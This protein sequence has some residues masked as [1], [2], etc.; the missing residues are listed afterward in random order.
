MKEIQKPNDILIAT[1]SSP[2]A[3]AM[4]LLRNDINI[5]NTSLLSKEEYKN[6]PFIKKQFTQDGV[7]N[8]DAFNK[9]YDA[10]ASKYWELEDDNLYKNLEQYIEYSDTSRYRPL[11][12]KKRDVGYTPEAVKNNPLQQQIGIEGFNIK[13]KPKLTPEEAAQ[14]G[15]IWDP[16]NKKWIEGSAEDR[17]LGSKVFG[18][19]LVYA[20]YEQDGWQANPITGEMG[21]HK[22]GEFITDENGQYFTELLGSRELMDKQVVS[23]ADILT[24]EKSAL[25]KIDFFDSD[26]YE[27]SL[28]GVAMKT[29]ASVLPYMIPG[30]NTYYGMFRM[31]TGLAS[32]LPTVYKSLEG[33]VMGEN[34]TGL[35]DAA[36]SLENWFR[37]FDPSMSRKGKS[38]FFSVESLGNMLADTFG[39]LYQQRGA[40]KLAEYIKKVPTLNAAKSNGAEIAKAWEQRSKLAKQLSLGY[41]SLISAADVY[42]DAL[43]GGYDKRTAGLSALMSAGALYGVMNLNATNS[44]GTWFLDKT[45]GYNPEVTKAPIIKQAKSLYK[46]MEDAVQTALTTKGSKQPIANVLSKFKA[47]T[48][49]FFDDVFRTGGEGIFANMVTEGIEEVSEEVVQDAVKGMIDTLSWLGYTGKEG[50]FG[51]W[52]NVFSKEGAAR[53]FQTFAGGALG[54]GLFHLQEHTIEPNLI[55]AFKDPNYRSQFE[56]EADKDIIDVILSGRTKE[57]IEELEKC[58]TIF[59][60]KRAATGLVDQNG[61]MVSLLANGQTTQADAVATAAIERVQM[62]D[63][64]INQY[65]RGVGFDLYRFDEETRKAL[66]HSFKEDFEGMAIEEYV[67]DKFKNSLTELYS[68]HQSIKAQEQ[69]QESTKK[70]SSKKTTTSAEESVQKADKA[71]I[72][73]N[74]KVLDDK[75]VNIKAFNEK[76]AKV[77]GFFSGEEWVQTTQELHELETILKGAHHLD[78]IKH[79]SFDYFYETNIKSPTFTTEFKDLELES[80]NP[81]KMTQKKAKDLY[82]KYQNEW[83]PE[84]FQELIPMLVK[85]KNNMHKIIDP[86]AKKFIEHQR[87]AEIIKSIKSGD[88]AFEMYK[89]WVD[90]LGDEDLFNDETLAQLSTYSTEE[91]DALREKAKVFKLNQYLTELNQFIRPENIADFIRLHPKA[92][93]LSDRRKIDYASKL[94]ETGAITIEG[95][96]DKQIEVLKEL[97]NIQAAVTRINFFNKEILETL[98]RSVNRIISQEG[99]YYDRLVQLGEEDNQSG[100]TSN[101]GLIQVGD[102]SKIAEV[103]FFKL[104]SMMDYLKDDEFIEEEQYKDIVTL[105]G[106]RLSVILNQLQDVS[107]KTPWANQPFTALQNSIDQAKWEDVRRKVATRLST[108]C[109]DGLTAESLEALKHVVP[110]IVLQTDEITT[111]KR[112]IAYQVL[113]AA[114]IIASIDSY[115]DELQSFQTKYDNSKIVTNPLVSAVHKILEL[116]GKTGTAKNM[117][118]WAVN[119]ALEIIDKKANVDLIEFSSAEKQAIKDA[120]G[121]LEYLEYLVTDSKAY[122]LDEDEYGSNQFVVNYLQT[123]GKSQDIIDKFLLLDADD[124]NYFKMV[125]QEVSQKLKDLA[126]IQTELSSDKTVEYN[127]NFEISV[128]KQARLFQSKALLDLK[129]LG[130]DGDDKE[131]VSIIS[132]QDK[133]FDIDSATLNERIGFVLRCKQNIAIILKKK[134][135]KLGTREALLEAI[136]N[137]IVPISDWGSPKGFEM[138]KDLFRSG[139]RSNQ[140]IDIAANGDI[141]L[142]KQWLIWELVSLAVVDQQQMTEVIT[143]ALDA[144]PEVYP[145]IDQIEAMERLMAWGADPKAFSYIQKKLA[146]AYSKSRFKAED[147]ENYAWSKL[148]L[149]NV[150]FLLGSGGAGKNLIVELMSDFLQKQFKHSYVTALSDVK[151]ADLKAQFKNYEAETLHKYFPGLDKASETYKNAEYDFISDLMQYKDLDDASKEAFL[152]DKD[153]DADTDKTTGI[154]TI[155]KTVQIKNASDDDINWITLTTQYNPDPKDKNINHINIIFEEGFNVETTINEN[156]LLIIDECTLLDNLTQQLIAREAKKKNIA[157]LQIGDPYQQSDVLRYKA[158]DSN[159]NMVETQVSSGLAGYMGFYLPQLEGSWRANCNLVRYNSSGYRSFITQSPDK[160]GSDVDFALNGWDTKRKNEYNNLIKAGKFKF[161][162]SKNSLDPKH[163]FMGTYI[164]PNESETKTVIDLIQ[165][166]EEGRTIAVIISND[167]DVDQVKGELKNLGLTDPNIKFVKIKDVQGAEYDYT[168]AY[169]LKASPTPPNSV[170]LDNITTVYTEITRGKWG[171]LV[172]PVSQ[173]MNDLFYS[174]GLDTSMQQDFDQQAAPTLASEAIESPHRDYYKQALATLPKRDTK[175]NI[176]SKPSKPETP[177]PESSELDPEIRH[178]S[179]QLPTEVLDEEGG[180]DDPGQPDNGNSKQTQHDLTSQRY[181]QAGFT[182]FTIGQG[183]YYHGGV[184]RDT[185]ASFRKTPNTL[186]SASISDIIKMPELEAFVNLMR[187]KDSDFRKL[188]DLSNNRLFKQAIEELGWASWHSRNPKNMVEQFVIFVRKLKMLTS[189]Q[190]ADFFYAISDYDDNVDFTIDKLND[191]EELRKKKKLLIR[192]V[193]PIYTDTNNIEQ[194]F[195]GITITA[196][197]WSKYKDADGKTQTTSQLIQELLADN[198]SDVEKEGTKYYCF[199]T[200]AKNI[201]NSA[202][203]HGDWRKVTPQKGYNSVDTS[204]S[205]AIRVTTTARNHRLKRDL[206]KANQQVL[207]NIGVN[208]DG[209]RQLK[210]NRVIVEDYLKLGYEIVNDIKYQWTPSK[211]TTSE[212]EEEFVKWYTQFRADALSEEGAERLKAFSK[213]RWIVLREKGSGLLIPVKISKICKLDTSL[214]DSHSYSK[215][216]AEGVSRLNTALHRKIAAGLA[217]LVDKN[218]ELTDAWQQYRNAKNERKALEQAQGNVFSVLNDIQNALKTN[219]PK[220]LSKAEL[221]AIE[222]FLTSFKNI[223]TFNTES[224]IAGDGKIPDLIWTKHW[225]NVF[226][227]GDGN[228]ATLASSLDRLLPDFFYETDISTDVAS[229]L[230]KFVMEIIY[231]SSNTLVDNTRLVRFGSEKIE[232][233]ME[234]GKVEPQDET[235]GIQDPDGEYSIN[236]VE[237]LRTAIADHITNTSGDPRNATPGKVKL[238]TAKAIEAYKNCVIQPGFGAA[239]LAEILATNFGPMSINRAGL[240]IHEFLLANIDNINPAVLQQVGIPAEMIE[241]LTKEKNSCKIN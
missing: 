146:D 139:E 141:T 57:L 92:W 89:K 66:R 140:A 61:N 73:A 71:N 235:G 184:D 172:I 200:K 225:N 232:G 193:V 94:I 98:L 90:E 67:R 33:L 173:D 37:K 114:D 239:K 69:D 241:M 159:G 62:L 76:L 95:Y 205:S 13:S 179:S 4:D 204:Q 192:H 44:L 233:T 109:S 188:M 7:F 84:D 238:A 30:F 27:K 20:Q 154:I 156:S 93:S 118:E 183:Y 70:D 25:N 36:S 11:N 5:D 219:P 226:A 116:Q 112:Q 15:R 65:I 16:D 240:P 197:G 113:N 202:D 32:T 78:P 123:W 47:Q 53:Y 56:L 223:I 35:T 2:Q 83:R 63:S 119:K 102:L 228:L 22:K 55:R 97:I 12:S 17:S 18:Q 96:N 26:G 42:N 163:L 133:D 201:H 50:S 217:Y 6:T 218:H 9:V 209:Q 58:K 24:K 149:D 48:R 86:D 127:H 40:A 38:K 111:D 82:T 115:I 196:Q 134:Q 142:N 19:T 185:V 107:D 51:G 31:A 160:K 41:M 64:F 145:R 110:S 216:D 190:S 34:T 85:I 80:T 137:E 49:N 104:D 151:T 120:L 121:A 227:R 237:E 210:Y 14:Q 215:E 138:Q 168:I 103:R 135:D 181:T 46:E 211:G 155:S 180:T 52:K 1:L 161:R 60:D 147:P 199:H 152:T 195:I 166:S 187:L 207:I 177:S 189:K 222:N 59:S 79:L 229:N 130:V 91:A 224:R 170:S 214:R 105:M 3:T 150:A 87:K 81:N 132:E 125:I 77:R 88:I 72:E 221:T 54:G 178:V 101:L 100:I 143:T 122:G 230:D 171:N 194:N 108:I 124:A 43:K 169:K 68:L 8:E 74:K 99:I 231:E 174:V 131:Q 167:A 165:K 175:K 157:V 153:L 117:A 213:H 176:P 28:G 10:A 206:E 212:R 21:Q 234:Q 191:D 23:V 148:V 208:E 45:V 164:S 158:K 236:S 198:N 29:V 182:D 129:V 106:T 162:Y 220:G 203:G 126:Q 39:Q 144:R 136:W 128:E 186:K 75:D